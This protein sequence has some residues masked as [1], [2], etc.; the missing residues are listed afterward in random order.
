VLPSVQT[1]TRKGP[2]T[3]HHLKA[4]IQ[5]GLKSSNATSHYAHHLLAHLQRCQAKL[6]F[7]PPAGTLGAAKRHPTRFW[8]RP[9]FTNNRLVE[10]FTSPRAS[11]RVLPQSSHCGL[12]PGGSIYTT[13]RHTSSMTT[14]YFF[15]F[16]LKLLHI[17]HHRH[18]F[19]SPIYMSTH[20]NV[21]QN[22]TITHHIHPSCILMCSHKF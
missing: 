17:T 4:F 13:R 12:S 3:S 10:P 6:G 22:F 2:Q 11:S 16:R 15:V 8:S 18:I 21:T 9:N 1:T 19:R 14:T 5:S 7:V 20:F